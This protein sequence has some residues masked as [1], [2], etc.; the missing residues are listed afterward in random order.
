MKDILRKVGYEFTE[1][2]IGPF[3]C[4]FMNI[5]DD[6]LVFFVEVEDIE[7]VEA[8]VTI[9]PELKQ[10]ILGLVKNRKLSEFSNV[11]LPAFLWDLYVVAMHDVRESTPFDEIEVSRWERDRFLARKVIVEYESDDI[12]LQSIVHQLLP[13]LDLDLLLSE[14]NQEPDA[15]QQMIGE[16]IER[17]ELPNQEP[18]INHNYQSIESYLRKMI[19]VIEE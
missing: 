13:E 7:Q 11:T 6:K 1:H 17:I 5:R 10:D 12:A 14:N 15:V 18:G 16:I 4:Y 3:H 19:L 9:L 2:E 8:F